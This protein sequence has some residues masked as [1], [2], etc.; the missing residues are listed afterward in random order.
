[1]GDK[2]IIKCIVKPFTHI[3]NQSLQTGTFPQKMNTAKVIPIYKSG[4]RHKFS[5]YRPVSLLSQ[6]S[7]ILEM[8]FAHRLE[9]FI[10]ENNLSDH[11]F[12]FREN[13]STLMAVMQ[14]VEEIATAIDKKKYT[15]GVFIDLKKAFDTIDH[16]LL[17]EK[18]ERYGIRGIAYSWLKSSQ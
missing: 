18:L 13:R 7:K 8:G 4:D 16:N 14:I 6:F 10:E 11:Q 5:N 1:M 15:V 2:K 9:H 17:M 3:C 12:E